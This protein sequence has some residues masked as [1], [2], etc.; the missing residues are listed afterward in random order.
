[1]SKPFDN[2]TKELLERYAEPWLRC[3][4]LVPDG[5]VRVIDADLS[6]VSA[7]ADKVFRIDGPTPY[8]VHIEM[9]SSADLTLPR[10]LLRYNV[11]L[12][13]RL[14]LRVRSVAVILRPEADRSNLTGSLQLHLPDGRM[15]STFPTKLCGPG[16][17]LSGRSFRGALALCRWRRYLMFLA[18]V[19]P[20]S[21]TKLMLV[22]SARRLRRKLLR[23]WRRP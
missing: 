6:T 13:L 3:F 23:L 16:A 21:S 19:C 10:R 17:V 4:G 9:Q 12:D 14:D 5:P 1:M 8:L 2:A 18:T 11:L 7:E 20:K 15:S 22:L